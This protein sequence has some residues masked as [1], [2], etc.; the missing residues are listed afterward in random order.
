MNGDEHRRFPNRIKD[1]SA[2][3]Y[4]RWRYELNVRNGLVDSA[5]AS[6]E[7]REFLGEASRKASRV[8]ESVTES[9]TRASRE[10]HAERQRRYRER[11][12]RKS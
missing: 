3:E 9:V 7:T 12:R 5:K 8:T 10:S 2:D 11:Q 4:W 6:R 1:F